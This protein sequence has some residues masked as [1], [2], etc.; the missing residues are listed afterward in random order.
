[1]LP[2]NGMILAPYLVAAETSKELRERPFFIGRKHRHW[3]LGEKPMGII[4]VE[5][6]AWCR[7]GLPMKAK[8]D[9]SFHTIDR[10]N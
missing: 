2:E 6:N 1:M 3:I 4:H 10:V 5:R 8:L 9:R 7:V